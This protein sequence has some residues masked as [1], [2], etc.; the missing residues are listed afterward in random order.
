MERQKRLRAEEEVE[1][2]KEEV[3]S[4]REEEWPSL[5]LSL[6]VTE[7]VENAEEVEEVKDEVVSEGEEEWPSLGLSFGAPEEVETE[8]EVE[9]VKDEVV[10]EREEEMRIINTIPGLKVSEQKLQSSEIQPSSET[11]PVADESSASSSLGELRF[12]DE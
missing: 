3:V 10:S 9:E 11:R 4:E 5:G 1:E 8:E 2:V 12:Q 7:E 6:G